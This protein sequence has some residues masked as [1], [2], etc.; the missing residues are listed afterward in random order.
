[1]FTYFSLYPVKAVHYPLILYLFIFTCY[2]SDTFCTHFAASAMFLLKSRALAACISLPFILES[3][4]LCDWR[5]LS[6]EMWHLLAVLCRMA[7]SL[8]TRLDREAPRLF[9]SWGKTSLLS[10][11]THSHQIHTRC[12]NILGLDVCKNCSIISHIDYSFVVYVL[13]LCKPCWF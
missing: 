11:F 13:Y 8:L 3:V 12:Y 5:Q 2:L 10:S 9:A 4:S 6:I 1:M 7:S